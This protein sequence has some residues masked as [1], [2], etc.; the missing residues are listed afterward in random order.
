M[1]CAFITIIC[2][3]CG[4]PR[5]KLPPL[6]PADA[7]RQAMA[8][9]D[10]DGDGSL[11]NGELTQCPGLSSSMAT[12][13][14]DKDGQVTEAEIRE[15][16]EEHRATGVALTSINCM[17]YLDGRPLEG[18]S[19]RFVPEGFQGEG[20]QMAVGETGRGGSTTLAI[21]GAELPGIHCGFYRVEISRKNAA[22]NEG[23]PAKYNSE[24]V[25]GQEVTQ[26]VPREGVASFQLRSR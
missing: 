19:I 26:R 15:R 8:T 13:D 5:V 24:S 25:L 4:P 11:S 10:T 18:A 20:I 17:V 22:D 7:G 14:K 16:L 6:D 2:S 1:V 9:F 3:A 21:P 23:L 12:V